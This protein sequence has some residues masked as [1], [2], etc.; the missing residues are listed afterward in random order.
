[1]SYVKNL[2]DL[3]NA[4]KEYLVVDTETS[5]LK[6]EIIELT[7]IKYFTNAQDPIVLFDSKIKPR[8][9]IDPSSSE[10]HHITD[11][12]VE[13]NQTWPEIRDIILEL[14]RGQI[15][16]AYNA[17]FDRKAFHR[18]DRTWDLE[19]FDWKKH[20]EWRCIMLAVGDLLSLDPKMR[21]FKLFIAAEMLGI[22]KEDLTLHSAS[23]DTI[24]AGRVMT[25]IL[26]FFEGKVSIPS[27]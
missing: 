15:V 27:H 9:P 8:N 5:G 21:W 7:I 24:L 25:F 19:K 22:S 6:G 26:D 20:S 11:S 12:L 3:V 10:I 18:S 23:G 13:N 17:L 1:M 16:L 14:T 4:K 2:V